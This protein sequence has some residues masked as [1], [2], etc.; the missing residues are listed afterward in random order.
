LLEIT[1]TELTEVIC[2]LKNKKSAGLDEI[3]SY[4]LRKCA[5]YML[6][7]LLE[8]IN[9]SIRKSVFP[10]TLKNRL[11]NQYIKNG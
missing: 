8:L 11:L 1:E 10:S 2:S 3:S 5:P 7:S 9:V 4:L 6:K